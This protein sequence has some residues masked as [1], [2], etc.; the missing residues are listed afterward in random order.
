MVDL[1][2]EA[3]EDLVEAEEVD[4]EVSEEE[5]LV[6]V[7]LEAA[8]KRLSDCGMWIADRAL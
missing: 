2:E 7:V 4:L 1:V 3:V 6:V 8:G 5:V